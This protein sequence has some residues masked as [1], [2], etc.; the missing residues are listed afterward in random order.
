MASKPTTLADYNQHVNRA[1]MQLSVAQA[2]I[3]DGAPLDAACSATEVAV[4]LFNASRARNAYLEDLTVSAG[5]KG[6]RE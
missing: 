5:T 3:E 1:L 6:A 2:Y 4:A